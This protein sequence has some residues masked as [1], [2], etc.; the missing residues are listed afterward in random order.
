MTEDP[1]GELW[2]GSVH[3]AKVFFWE[4]PSRLAQHSSRTNF[5]SGTAAR[6]CNPIS[7]FQ[8]VSPLSFPCEHGGTPLGKLFLVPYDG[9]QEPSICRYA[10]PLLEAL[11]NQP[12]ALSEQPAGGTSFLYGLVIWDFT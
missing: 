12:R 3:L 1:H 9:P 6:M 4:E 5:V 11:I 2:R 7:S 8:V 10:V